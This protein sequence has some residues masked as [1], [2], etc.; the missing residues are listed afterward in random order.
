MLFKSVLSGAQI[1]FC[2]HLFLLCWQLASLTWT[3]WMSWSGCTTTCGGGTRTRIRTCMSTNGGF[4][5]GCAGSNS[6]TVNCAAEE[7]RG[8]IVITIRFDHLE[9]DKVLVLL[10]KFPV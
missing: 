6:Q 4:Q 7:C 10:L 9:N 1:F 8:E 5:L 2:Q 3:A